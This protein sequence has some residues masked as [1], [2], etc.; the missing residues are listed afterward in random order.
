MELSVVVPVYDEEDVLELFAARLRAALDP[1]GEP[2]EVVVV[3]DGSR[4]AT[5]RLLEAL[6]AGWPQLRVVRLRRN[7]GH[8]AALTAGLDRS[9]GAW[10]ASI[11]AD[12]QD[13][14]ELVP[15]MLTAARREGVDVVYGVRDDRTSDTWFK[16]RTAG[17]YY[18]LM[19]REA[20]A[21][22]PADA[23][24]FRLLSRR[25]V[26]EL[27]ALP[28]RHRVY[29]LLVPWLGHPSTVVAYRRDERAA[30]TSKYPLARMVRLGTDSLTSFSAR[31]LRVATWCGVL[32]SLVCLLA[33]LTAVGAHLS[34]ATVPGWA[35]TFVAV[36]FVGAVQL[37]CLGL[38]G[39][40]VGRLYAEAQHRPPYLVASDTADERRPTRPAS[41]QR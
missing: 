9:R 7:C 36:L 3:D 32:G 25:V 34:G 31:P 2:Y 39:E 40:Y 26:D 24:D 37:L 38:L 41:W 23:G 6:R 15:V 35:S 29:R 10:V 13:P 8:Q 18:G 22:V 11:D 14:P 33:M 27:A 19:R 17:L 1:L 30:G 20:G 28:E 16:R 21:D 5:P 12:L 4:D